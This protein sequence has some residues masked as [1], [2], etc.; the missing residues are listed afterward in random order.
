MQPSYH[1]DNNNCNNNNNNHNKNNQLKG[2]LVSRCS[3]A[4]I[5]TITMT[6]G[7]NNNNNSNNNNN[8]MISLSGTWLQ[9]AATINSS[10]S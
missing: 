1:L 5:M 3:K 2:D 10:L 9:D 8:N 4:I 6:D 7:Y